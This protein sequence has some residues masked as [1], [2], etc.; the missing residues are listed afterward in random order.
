MESTSSDE[1]AVFPG[2]KPSAAQPTQQAPL[3]WGLFFRPKAPNA[4]AFLKSLRSQ[5]YRVLSEAEAQGLADQVAAEKSGF[6]RLLTLLQALGT[7][8]DAVLEFATGLAELSLKR[9]GLLRSVEGEDDREAIDIA[10]EWLQKA[11]KGRLSPVQRDALLV[12]V[13]LRWRT[14]RL[15]DHQVLE[16]LNLLVSRR[17]GEK[18]PAAGAEPP[19][20]PSEALLRIVTGKGNLKGILGLAAAWRYQTKQIDSA[21]RIAENSRDEAVTG[22]ERIQE[23]A[24]RLQQEVDQLRTVGSGLERRVQELE[25]HA[26]DLRTHFQHRL[27][28]MRGRL[29]GALDGEISRWLE[30]AY[31]ASVAEPPRAKVI[32]ERL[33]MTLA[34]IRR[35]VT[36]LRSLG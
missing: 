13:L 22:R 2:E 31:E 9:Y 25:E 27:D 30:T 8:Q 33:E 5:G 17:R 11:S 24:D 16:I 14:G 35:Q 12:F 34:N 26:N 19:P 28:E 18:R 7:Q 32:Q 1:K 15:G 3:E 36:W 29:Q 20:R 6:P 10:R 23:E 21:R 4:S